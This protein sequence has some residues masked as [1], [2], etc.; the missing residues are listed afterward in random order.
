MIN[1]NP[2]IGSFNYGNHQLNILRLDLIHPK[3]GGNKFFKLKYNL[4][5]AKAEGFSKILTFGGAHSNHI[6]STA[7]LCKEEK[8]EAIGVIRGEENLIEQS[9]TLQFALSKGMKL[10]FVSREKYK[11]KTEENLIEELKNKFGDFYLVPEGGNN[12]E[13]VKGCTKI[14]TDE[15]KQYDYVFCACGTAAT[16][17]GIKISASPK[18]IVIGIS[19]LKGE[20]KLIDE[21]NK[22]FKEFNSG[23]IQAD[24]DMNLKHSTILTGYHFGGYAKH[25]KELLDFKKEFEKSHNIPLDYIYTSK[26]F[27]AVFELIKTQ[28]IKSGS[29]ILIVHSGG[30]QGNAGYESRYGL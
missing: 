23:S 7:A 5:K 24:V 17:S 19:V 10:Y 2:I 15:L 18:Q 8:I 14:L 27:F 21:A 26:L 9:P 16:F 20:N 1:Y 3:C 28:R 13:G 29:K 30:L 4:H 25:T 11:I 22:W 6:Y 12:Y